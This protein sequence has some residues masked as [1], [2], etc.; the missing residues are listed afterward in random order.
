MSKK[1][2]TKRRPLTEEETIK[3]IEIARLAS[4]FDDDESPQFEDVFKRIADT[5]TLY[6]LSSDG[7]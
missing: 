2:K 3:I 6:P 1:Q 7:F 4:D 5:V